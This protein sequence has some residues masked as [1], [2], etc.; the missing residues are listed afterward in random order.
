MSDLT[1]RDGLWASATARRSPHTVAPVETKGPSAWGHTG[2][3][4]TVTLS[5]GLRKSPT[6]ARK[7]HGMG[8]FHKKQSRYERFVESLPQI[9]LKAAAKSGLTAVAT[10]IGVSLASTGVSVLRERKEGS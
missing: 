2:E 9:Q 1:G 8:L 6:E 10:L 4:E 7:E 5:S 3:D